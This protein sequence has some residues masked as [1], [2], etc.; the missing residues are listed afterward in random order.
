MY[1]KL[2]KEIL[3]LKKQRE[4]LDDRITYLIRLK[5]GI[6]QAKYSVEHVDKICQ[7]QNIDVIKSRMEKV[8]F[9]NV[10]NDLLMRSIV[11]GNKKALN[12]KLRQLKEE[13][14]ND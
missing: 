8:A 1:E 13:G 9:Y 7:C 5:E 4:D 11:E 6:E 3:K 10:D 12:D 2:D 14:L